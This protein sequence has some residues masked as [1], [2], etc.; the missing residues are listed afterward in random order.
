MNANWNTIT[1]DYRYEINSILEMTKNDDEA[2]RIVLT[3]PRKKL[4]MEC[5][6]HLHKRNKYAINKH[7]DTKE[8]HLLA[9]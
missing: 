6:S 8:P 3:T 5:T 2:E 7:K 9:P 4:K 1:I